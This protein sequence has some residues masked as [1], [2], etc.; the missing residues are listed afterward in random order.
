M[1]WESNLL[2]TLF[3]AASVYFVSGCR[4]LHRQTD[5]GNKLGADK[6]LQAESGVAM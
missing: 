2:L 1:L 5:T 3:F 6:Q 4:P